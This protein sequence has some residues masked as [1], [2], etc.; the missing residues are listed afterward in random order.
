MTAAITMSV[1]SEHFAVVNLDGLEPEPLEQRRAVPMQLGADR[2]ALHAAPSQLL[3]D[4]L[5]QDGA[6]A[7]L[8]VVRVDVKDIHLGVQGLAVMEPRADEPPVVA[9]QLAVLTQHHGMQFADRVV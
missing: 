2:P 5:E 7:S 6:G 1:F 9:D 4:R 8:A 3:L